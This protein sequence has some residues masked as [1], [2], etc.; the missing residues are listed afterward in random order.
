VNN[1][2]VKITM[3]PHRNFHKYSWT[4]PDGKTHNQIDHILIERKQHTSISDVRSFR[5]IYCDTD[6]YLVVTKVRER[7][8]V[9]K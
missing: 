7:F 9:S 8:A 6:H 3:F 2:D 1:L 4:Y 5:R